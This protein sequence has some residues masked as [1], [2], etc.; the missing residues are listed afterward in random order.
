[1]LAHDVF[2]LFL[3]FPFSTSSSAKRRVFYVMFDKIFF[4]GQNC[5]LCFAP[6]LTA[7]PQTSNHFPQC[8]HTEK[9]SPPNICTEINSF[10]LPLKAQG[11]FSSLCISHSLSHSVLL[12]LTFPRTDLNSSTVL[13]QLTENLH[14]GQNLNEKFSSGENKNARKRRREIMKKSLIQ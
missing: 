2:F 3:F 5:R 14:H 7:E 9:F 13:M 12:L 8:S 11:V 10:E 4:T 6:Q 1:M